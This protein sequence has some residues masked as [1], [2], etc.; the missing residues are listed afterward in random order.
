MKNKHINKFPVPPEICS[1]AGLLSVCN[2]FSL[3]LLFPL[4]DYSGNYILK[5]SQVSLNAKKWTVY[6]DDGEFV[7]RWIWWGGGV[8]EVLV[9]KGGKSGLEGGGRD[10]GHIAVQ[11]WK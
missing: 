2:T 5:V 4:T 1:S 7:Y 8:Q 9:G 3:I 10:L 6:V 11:K